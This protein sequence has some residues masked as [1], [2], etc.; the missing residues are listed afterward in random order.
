DEVVTLFK[1]CDTP[2]QRRYL[3]V[4]LFLG[5]TQMDLATLERDEFVTKDGHY[6]V[7]K[8][9]SKTGI[10]GYWWVCPEL[11]ALIK[12]GANDDDPD[13]LLY[14]TER[15]NPLVWYSENGNRCDST[16]NVWRPI[17]KRAQQKGVRPL[18][19]SALRKFALQMV[20]NLSSHELGKVF[21]AQTISDGG[22]DVNEKHYT[23]RGVSVGIGQ[24]Q[25]EQV[26]EVQKTMYAQLKPH[27]FPSRAPDTQSI[28][29][30]SKTQTKA[31]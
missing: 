16:K 15:G 27:L 21:A 29:E 12:E 4:P 31:A 26:I 13:G 19:F 9:R 30:Q 11:A 24:T 7:D 28:A 1:C 8:L 5:W 6:Y 20:K 2:L 23:G 25:F 22:M 3:L 18:P 10:Q 17:M 14:R